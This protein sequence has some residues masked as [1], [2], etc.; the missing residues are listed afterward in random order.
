MYLENISLTFFKNYQ[1]CELRFSP[2]IN[3]IMGPNGSGKTN[4]LDAIHYL[5]LT[6][7]AL[8]PV[9]QQSIQHNADYFSIRGTFNLKG[10]NHRIQCSCKSGDKKI[11]QKDKKPYAKLSEHIGVFPLVLISPYDTDIL[12]EGS[13]TRRKFMD[14]IISQID[15][16]YLQNLLKYQRLLNHRNQLLKNFALKNRFDVQ[17]INS[18]D[19][20]MLELMRYIFEKREQFLKQFTPL[21]SKHYHS[22]TEGKEHVE[23]DYQ[24]DL[25]TAGFKEKFLANHKRDL[26]LQ[27]TSLGIHKDD[28]KCLLESHPIRKFGSQGQQ[29]SYV[30]ALKLAQFELLCEEN[31]F[32]PILL[33][34]DIFDK[35]DD[36]RIEKLI[37]MV[38][39][40]IFGQLFITDAR[41]ERTARILDKVTVDMNKYLVDNGSIT[42]T[43]APER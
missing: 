2:F 42:E 22:L 38:S 23:L 37:N 29:K 3:C 1:S 28:L 14:G 41:P 32:K 6:K 20:P 25:H 11:I 8:N 5:A 13:A 43:S 12:R 24:S 36:G 34:D 19:E 18:Y 9:D 40:K 30:I 10:K 15:P 27:R 21:F 26:D 4:L 7:S 16:Q 33:L 35:L 39:G 31:G 17:L